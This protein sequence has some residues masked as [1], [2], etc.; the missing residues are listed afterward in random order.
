MDI[1][2][3]TVIY[4]RKF[5]LGDFNSLHAETWYEVE[6]APDDDP[7]IVTAALWDLARSPQ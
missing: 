7:K 6:L 5:N 2:K 4:G 1:K 3:I